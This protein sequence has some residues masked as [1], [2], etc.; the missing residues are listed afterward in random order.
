MLGELNHNSVIRREYTFIDNECSKQFMRFAMFSCWLQSSSGWAQTVEFVVISWMKSRFFLL[1]RGISRPLK[2]IKYSKRAFWLDLGS[3][4]EHVR[5]PRRETR[6][7]NQMT[8]SLMIPLSSGWLANVICGFVEVNW[9]LGG[10]LRSYFCC[11]RCRFRLKL[12]TESF[13]IDW[14][15]ASGIPLGKLS[16]HVRKLYFR[17]WN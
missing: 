6:K 4:R 14:T 16:F 17:L 10:F 8:I 15:E 5:R 12:Q 13:A 11:L 7:L 1:L 3:S 9:A 2:A